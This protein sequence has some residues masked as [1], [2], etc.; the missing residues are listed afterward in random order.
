[1]AKY[2]RI[3]ATDYSPEVKTIIIAGIPALLQTR[4]ILLGRLLNLAILK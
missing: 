3:M 1:M 4:L 2:H